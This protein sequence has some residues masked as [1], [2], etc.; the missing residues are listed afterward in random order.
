MHRFYLPPDRARGTRLE[1]TEGEARHAATVLRMRPGDPATVLD[2]QGAVLDCKVADCAPKRVVLEVARRSE[3]PSPRWE[4]TL[5]QALPKG[6]GFEDIIEKATELGVRRIVPLL[7]TRIIPRLGSDVS[8]KRIKWQ[9]V[10]IEAIKQCGNPWL[11]EVENP[12]T[13]ADWIGRAPRTDLV[14]I[15]SLQPGSRHPR[16]YFD[17]FFSGP[18]RTSG[19]LAIWIGPEGDFTPEETQA[20]VRA[21]A[22][23]ITLGALVLR[24]E[25]AAITCLALMNHELSA[26]R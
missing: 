7:A 13:P 15:G 20:A 11:P 21:G 8:A 4:I 24:V 23:P 12:V 16:V 3:S 6:S 18:G 2:G 22:K 19:S 9:H 14:L 1:L 10:A 26:P 17:E 5:V 25:T